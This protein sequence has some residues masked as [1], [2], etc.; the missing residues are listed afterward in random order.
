MSIKNNKLSE[1]VIPPECLNGLKEFYLDFNQLIEF[2]EINNE[3]IQLTTL[4][5]NN[6][7]IALLPIEDLSLTRLLHLYLDSNP[8]KN[9]EI[10]FSYSPILERLSLSQT[11]L[12]SL[13]LGR[14]N[15]RMTKL[16]ISDNHI[17]FTPK[18]SSYF[19]KLEYL[20]V[21]RTNLCSTESFMP[22]CYLKSLKYLSL[23]NCKIKNLPPEIAELKKL[24]EISFIKNDLSSF[25]NEFYTMKLKLINLKENPVSFEEKE[26][27]NNSFKKTTIHY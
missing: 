26:K 4:S 14:I 13:P 20:D 18:F 2:P 3:Y 17:N 19:P 22:L 9:A 5:L 1:I 24:R 6:N 16:I 7:Y 25:P 11:N 27:L 21:S 15:N 10:A 23:D 8:L 12:K